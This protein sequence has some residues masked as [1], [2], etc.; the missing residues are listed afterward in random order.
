MAESAS[1]WLIAGLGNP[2]PKYEKS[3]HNVGF[4]VLDALAE[5]ERASWRS[6]RTNAL[7]AK[8]NSRNGAT[9]QLLKPLTF[10]NLSGQAVG[11]A[12]RFYHIDPSHIV[13]VHDEMDLP[14]GQLRLK[15]GGGAAGHNGIKSIISHIGAD[16]YRL[17]VGIGKAPGVGADFVLGDF[18]SHELPIFNEVKIAAM[19]ALEAL[20]IDGLAKAQNRFHSL[21]LSINK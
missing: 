3:R 6:E 1:L 21:D 9:C 19:Q 8:I 20:I 10:M 15:M 2:G 16:F 13:V 17:R 11:E 18:N 14:L 5:A 7:G 12:A 4:M